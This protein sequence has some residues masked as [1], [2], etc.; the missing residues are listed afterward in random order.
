MTQ[1]GAVCTRNGYHHLANWFRLRSRGRQLENIFSH[2]FRTRFKLIATP[3]G[4]ISLDADTE[5]DYAAMLENADYFRK[6]QAEILAE[7]SDLDIQVFNSD[8]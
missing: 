8:Q 4:I 2:L 1:A 6:V 3:Y 7:I 5:E